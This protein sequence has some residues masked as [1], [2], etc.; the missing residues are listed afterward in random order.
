MP[1]SQPPSDSPVALNPNP[2]GGTPLADTDP[3]IHPDAVHKVSGFGDMWVA[4]TA[5]PGALMRFWAW[6]N[7][8]PARRYANAA[9]VFAVLFA[10]VVVSMTGHEK[11]APQPPQ[12]VAAGPNVGTAKLGDSW[13]S[14]AKANGITD[15]HSLVD[16]NMDLVRAN[17]TWCQ[18][19]APH[20]KPISAAY[21]AGLRKDG[22]PRD[23]DYCVLSSYKGETLA[24]TTLREK[25]RYN[26]PQ[27]STTAV[28]DNVK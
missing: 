24:I 5:I 4:I 18:A 7:R 13:I 28:A 19:R 16:A 10:V 2:A 12:V 20:G 25:Q 27:V 17:T 9:F 14:I 23:D 3:G 22:Q 6:A 8:T 11:V 15:W 21:L 26:L 1:D